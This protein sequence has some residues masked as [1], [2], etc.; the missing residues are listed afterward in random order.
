MRYISC[1]ALVLLALTVFVACNKDNKKVLNE[2]NLPAQYFSINADADT[3]IKGTGGTTLSIPAHIFIDS[4]GAITHGPIVVE[5]KEA[6]KPI[7]IVLGG[8]TTMADNKVLQTGGMLYVNATA[9]GKPLAIV[10][11]QA[12]EVHV[13]ADTI[14]KDMQLYTGVKADNHINWVSPQPLTTPTAT[15]SEAA[16]QDTCCT[17]TNAE[18]IETTG[19]EDSAGAVNNNEMQEFLVAAAN[20]AKGT[21]TFSQDVQAT[22]IFSLKKL[23]WANIDR[24]YTDPRTQQVVFTTSVKDAGNYDHIY[25]TLIIADSYIP[26]YQKKDN[27]FSFTHGDYEQPSL[28]VG[29]NAVILATTY[30]KGIAYYAIHKLQVTASQ[31]ISLDLHPTDSIGLKKI[32]ESEL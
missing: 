23:G 5:L 21:N 1:A 24:L 15:E 31:E 28:P 22:Y 8:L 3:V 30:K 25:T 29:A 19:D 16:K 7:D 26:G 14:A 10:T 32:L 6:L 9:Q 18:A 27:S 17:T 20:N 2:N 11:G 4:S 12:I 13:P